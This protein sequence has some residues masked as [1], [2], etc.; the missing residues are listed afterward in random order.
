[1]ILNFAKLRQHS[2]A[3]ASCDTVIVIRPDYAGAK[4]K[5]G[6]DTKK[7]Y[8]TTPVCTHM[9]NSAD[10]RNHRMELA[11]KFPHENKLFLCKD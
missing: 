3:L 1:M 5:A 9:L 6:N 10:G 7:P 2:D 8:Y 4:Q 11:F